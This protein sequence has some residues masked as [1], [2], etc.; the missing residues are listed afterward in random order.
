MTTTC[1]KL[2]VSHN[3]KGI[4]DDTFHLLVYKDCSTIDDII[5]ECQRFEEPKSCRVA[6]LF[7]R[8]PNVATTTSSCKD[9]QPQPPP[10][11]ENFLRLVRRE[12]EAASPSALQVWTFEETRPTVSLIQ[13]GMCEELA[14]AGIQPLCALSRPA[15]SPVPSYHPLS[16]YSRDRDP[17]QWRTRDDRPIR[18]N[19][20]GVGHI[21]HY[22]HHRWPSSPRALY[23]AEDIQRS[24]FHGHEDPSNPND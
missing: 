15:V 1:P 11:T 23:R 18:F 3:L 19:C 7:V 24:P 13:A 21:S 5:R 14:N 6:R 22:C 10:S 9:V 4:T 2:T 17:N 20:Y 12:I 8:L 16:T